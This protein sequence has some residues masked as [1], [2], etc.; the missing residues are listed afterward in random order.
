MLRHPPVSTPTDTLFP[1]S[2]LF[3]S[4][5]GWLGR[6][7][8]WKPFLVF[9]CML[10]AVGL[11]TVFLTYPLG[12]GFWLAFTDTKIGR[13]GVFTGLENF[14]SLSN[15][16]IFWLSVFNTIVYTTVAT[17]LKFGLGLWLALLLNERSEDHPS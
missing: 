12:L 1:Y 7:L 14:I 10:P 13:A 6:L 11:L 4:P 17:V 2:T 3:R 5:A 8:D 15:D 9:I 16:P